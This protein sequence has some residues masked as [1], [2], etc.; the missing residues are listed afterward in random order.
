MIEIKM[1]QGAK[2]GHGGVLLG[3]KVTAEIAEARGVQIGEDCVSPSSHSSFSTPLELLQFVQQ[4]RQ[5]QYR[6]LL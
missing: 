2:P 4:H 1:S 6:V 3:P 5:R